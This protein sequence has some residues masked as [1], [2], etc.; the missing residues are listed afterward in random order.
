[1][2]NQKSDNIFYIYPRFS[3][4]NCSRYAN[5]IDNNFQL[6]NC[7]R[8]ANVMNNKAKINIFN[9]DNSNTAY[10]KKKNS[11]PLQTES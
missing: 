1:M 3:S 6:M 7:F 2:P 5:V 8:H 9:G 11:Q 4:T 10:I